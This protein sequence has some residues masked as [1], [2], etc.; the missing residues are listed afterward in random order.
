MHA[1]RAS[2]AKNITCP[3]DA[4]DAATIDT[5]AYDGDNFYFR[6]YEGLFDDFHYDI[7]HGKGQGEASYSSSGRY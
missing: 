3:K 2:I 5:I 6:E 7:G 4:K 1:I